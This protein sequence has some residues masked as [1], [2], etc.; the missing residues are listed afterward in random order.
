MKHLRAV[1][2]S[3]CVPFACALG[4]AGP[5][6][7]ALVTI[8]LSAKV[9]AISGAGVIGNALGAGDMLTGSYTYDTGTPDTNPASNVGDYQHAASPFGIVLQGGG[10]TFMS[11]PAAVDFLVEVVDG[12]P[13]DAF[14]M[15]SYSNADVPEL[16]GIHVAH[17]SW[18]LKDSSGNALS[19]TALFAGSP[20]LADFPDYNVLSIQGCSEPCS[21][22]NAAGFFQIDARVVPLPSPLLLVG[23]AL[24]LLALRAR[25]RAD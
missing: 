18:F 17:I 16:P 1:L 12:N 22:N 19:S 2:A 14:G 5:A 6:S 3:L 23:S 9:T 7:A 25:R 8:P 15:R 24:C 20:V 21:E 4:A 11:N 13:G 10:L